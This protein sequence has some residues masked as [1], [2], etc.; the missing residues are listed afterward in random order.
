MNAV[1]VTVNGVLVRRNDSRLESFIEAAEPV[2]LIGE[3][4]PQ[5]PVPSSATSQP[6]KLHGA[7]A[8]SVPWDRDADF[9]VTVRL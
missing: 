8:E 7:V 4:A 1:P 6:P 5:S 2:A 3:G 9:A